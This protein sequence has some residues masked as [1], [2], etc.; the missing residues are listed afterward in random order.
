MIIGLS[1][2]ARSG[3]DT[4]ADYLVDNYGFKRVAFADEIRKA[5]LAINPFVP[6]AYFL[7]DV[8]EHE[9]WEVAKTIPHVRVMMQNF[10]VF[11]RDEW[12]AQFWINQAFRHMDKNCRDEQGELHHVV[13]TD[14]RFKNEADSITGWTAK[15]GTVVRVNRPSVQAINNHISETELD[16]YAFKH[17]L[18]NDSDLYDLHLQVE[19][20][21]RE[22]NIPKK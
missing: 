12:G 21:M 11:V 19:E 14:V 7:K 18:N 1:G 8:V 5:L 16:D 9:G 20:L 2:Y 10:G 15:N 3:K 13:I 17:I 4:V 6:N 22:F